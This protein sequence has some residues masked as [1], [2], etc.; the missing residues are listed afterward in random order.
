MQHRATSNSSKTSYKKEGQAAGD[1]GEAVQDQ[2]LQIQ[3]SGDLCRDH[4]PKESL[5]AKPDILDIDTSVR[6]SQGTKIP[7]QKKGSQ[8]VSL[9]SDAV[10]HSQEAENTEASSPSR[11]DRLPAEETLA[12]RG[13]EQPPLS[14]MVV[15]DYRPSAAIHVSFPAPHTAPN[16]GTQ[17]TPDIYAPYYQASA[18]FDTSSPQSNQ[19]PLPQK[20]PPSLNIANTASSPVPFSPTSTT[21]NHAFGSLV[22]C[23]DAGPNRT[24]S[25]PES[26]QRSAKGCLHGAVQRPPLAEKILLNFNVGTFADIR[27]FL[28]HEYGAFEPTNFLLHGLIISQSPKLGNLLFNGRYALDY[29]GLK[30]LHIHLTDRF[31]TPLAIEAALRVCYGETVSNFTGSTPKTHPLRTK[32]QFSMNWMRESLAFAAA[33]HLFGLQDV[34]L[35]GLEIASKIINWDNIELALSFALESGNHR[36]HSPSASVVPRCISHAGYDSDSS[37]NTTVLTP[38]TSQESSDTSPSSTY[39]REHTSR[40][41]LINQTDVSCAEDL[42]SR[43]LQYIATHLPSCWNFDKAALP[44]AHVD[45]LPLTSD[46]ESFVAKS[47]LSKIQFGDHPSEGIK[48]SSLDKI[49]SS[50]L[51]SLPFVY[52]RALI[53]IEKGTL[54]KLLSTIVDERER[55]RA[56]T[57]NNLSTSDTRERVA[58]S[59]EWVEVGYKEHIYLDNG[60]ACL[61]RSYVGLDGNDH[62]VKSTQ[63]ER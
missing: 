9:A 62:R 47:R 19:Y 49:I 24:E 14:Q 46:S 48:A 53:N 32:A 27:L 10:Q 23:Q 16:N 8:K 22:S 59:V 36:R 25:R 37:T 28:S 44:I 7:D 35:R 18:P 60:R 6:Q 13:N 31:V 3:I 63:Q 1:P 55:R 26:Q 17:Y 21:D 34:V 40:D 2:N 45:R 4:G 50:T 54:T 5:E 30:V 61:G 41:I 57:L 11:E 38:D 15:P 43:C 52:L 58:K 20:A 42:L 51:L 56:L 33:G 12:F 39:R 29:D